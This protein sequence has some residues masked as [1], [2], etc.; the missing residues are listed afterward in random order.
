MAKKKK[1]DLIPTTYRLPSDVLEELDQ[2]A[3]EQER[4]GNVS[5]LVR[6]ILRGWVRDRRSVKNKSERSQQ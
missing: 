1:P 4:E 2:A 5:L 3:Q 6:Q